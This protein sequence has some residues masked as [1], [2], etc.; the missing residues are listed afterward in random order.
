MTLHIDPDV[1][2]A[3]AGAL[4]DIGR[5]QAKVQLSVPS[6]FDASQ[7]AALDAHWQV[8]IGLFR[9]QATMEYLDTNTRDAA[10]GFEKIEAEIEAQAST[11]PV[12]NQP[13]VYNGPSVG[14]PR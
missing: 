8:A 6:G 9:L 10:A 7:N 11:W 4:G 5:E 12:S 14:G 2:K 1:A 13:P 3:V